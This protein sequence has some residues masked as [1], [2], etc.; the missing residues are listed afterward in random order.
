M[1]PPSD[2]FIG[3]IS[4]VKFP[5]KNSGTHYGSCCKSQ[6]H[7]YL[8]SQ[9]DLCDFLSLVALFETHPLPGALSADSRGP[10]YEKLLLE[11]VGSRGADGTHAHGSSR[12][13]SEML[14]HGHIHWIVTSICCEQVS[15]A[16]HISEYL[17]NEENSGAAEQV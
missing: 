1:W 10:R 7:T 16:G 8:P 14:F 12:P 15:A 9:Q 2:K 4:R 11:V 6:V 5:K 3:N 13:S 17:A